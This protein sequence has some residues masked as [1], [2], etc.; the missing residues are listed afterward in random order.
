MILQEAQSIDVLDDIIDRVI[1]RFEKVVTSSPFLE[2]FDPDNQLYLRIIEARK[3]WYGSLCRPQ[4]TKN[5]T[6]QLIS[7]VKQESAF[8]I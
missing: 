5:H 8:C 7:Y 1:Q 2:I 6:I 4:I 3:A